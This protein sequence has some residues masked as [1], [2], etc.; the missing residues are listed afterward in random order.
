[1]YKM[2]QCPICKKEYKL[3][4]INTHVERL[5]TDKDNPKY[6][7]HREVASAYQE[8][9]SK[10]YIRE[11]ARKYYEKHREKILDKQRKV[12]KANH[13]KVREYYEHYYKEHADELEAWQ[14]EYYRKNQDQI[15]QRRFE[16]RKATACFVACSLCKEFFRPEG[17]SR[18]KAVC[19]GLDHTPTPPRKKRSHT[20]KII[21]KPKEAPQLVHM[22]IKLFT[23]HEISGTTHF[24]FHY[25]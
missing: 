10:E 3:S 2:E 4:Y 23:G 7:K 17:M 12:Y 15:N 18:H 11:R 24:G 9:L 20:Y 1:M 21:P 25:I 8:K 13:E 22:T 14:K 16:K 5:H 19:L 6:V